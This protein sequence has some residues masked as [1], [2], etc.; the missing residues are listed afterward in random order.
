MEIPSGSIVSGPSSP[1]SPSG[2]SSQSGPSSPSGPSGAS[3]S[4][5]PSTA[6]PLPES[7]I[8]KNSLVEIQRLLGEI[9]SVIHPFFAETS[10]IKVVKKQV[11]WT[12]G[13]RA[14]QVKTPAVTEV[15]KIPAKFVSMIDSIGTMDESMGTM[16]ENMKSLAAAKTNDAGENNTQENNAQEGGRRKRHKTLNKRRRLRGSRRH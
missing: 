1:S 3:G 5:G 8:M 16:A 15:I 2:P 7:T 14:G 6:T 9:R 13:R 10:E 4:I 12:S 11:N